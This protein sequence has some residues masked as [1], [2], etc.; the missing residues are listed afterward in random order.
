MGQQI[1]FQDV[2]S[3]LVCDTP[4]P[5]YDM[6]ISCGLPNE[7]GDVPPEM[8]LVPG[9]LTMGLNVSMVKARGDSMIGVGIHD[10][11]LLM[12]EST[13]HFNNGE[14]VAAVLDGEEMLKTYY[15]DEQGRHWLVP[16]NEH[17]KATLLKEE[18]NVRFLGR[19]M[20]HFNKPHDTMRNIHA[21]IAR[22]EKKK[23][24]IPI[25]TRN[26]VAYALKRVATIIKTGR[27]WLAPCR[28]LMDHSY[29]ATNRYDLFC[30]LV[31]ETLPD[32]KHLPQAAE[33][34]RM[35]VDCF[36]KPFEK[37]TDE[38]AP[39]HGKRY[40]GYYEAGKVMLEELGFL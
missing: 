39:V 21:A 37:W 5:Y 38:K 28:V 25:L 3:T 9:I 10:G 20:W 33:L 27:Q 23:R 24:E 8:M 15:M 13:S 14:V 18:M 40:Q 30:E 32:H 1:D 7:M 16:A 35:A 26:D 22:S 17:Y 31:R 34:Q 11:D 2:F 6:G 19:L 36:S 4:V 12:V 29:I